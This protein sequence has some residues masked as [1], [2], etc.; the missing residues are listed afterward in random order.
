MM[1]SSSMES[2]AQSAAKVGVEGTAKVSQ[3]AVM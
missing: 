2:I 3:I 1:I